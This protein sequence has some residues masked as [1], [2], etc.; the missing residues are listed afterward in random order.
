[1]MGHCAVLLN[2][3]QVLISGG[4]VLK[5]DSKMEE[6][7]SSTFIYDFRYAYFNNFNFFDELIG[8]DISFQNLHSS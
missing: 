2:K 1:M 5:N 8:L 7:S 6:Y 3:Y 4:I